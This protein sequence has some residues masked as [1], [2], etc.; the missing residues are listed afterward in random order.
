MELLPA[1]VVDTVDPDNLGR[2]K[3]WLPQAAQCT[4]AIRSVSLKTYCSNG[5][6]ED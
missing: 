2:I 6:N 4:L 1:A 5:M 3:V